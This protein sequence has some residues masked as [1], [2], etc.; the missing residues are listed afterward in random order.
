[1]VRKRVAEE[2]GDPDGD[3]DAGTAELL[4]WDDREPGDPPRRLVPHRPDA[5]QREDLGEVVALGAHRARAPDR[6][7]DAARILTGVGAVAGEQRV[8]QRA[9]DLP[10]AAGRDGLG[11]DGV[12]VA[13]RRQ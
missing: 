4:P 2:A 5:D 10:G 13:A 11:V 8:G 1:D 6:E 9:A 3:V 12:E 7:P